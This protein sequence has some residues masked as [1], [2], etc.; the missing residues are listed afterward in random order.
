MLLNKKR[1]DISK[2][3]ERK[4]GTILSYVGMA[5][6]TAISLLYTPYMIRTVGQ[7]EYGLYNTLSSI[8]GIIAILELGFT[9][10]YIQYYSKYVHNNEYGKL[11]S[12]NTLFSTIFAIIALITLT[13]GLLCSF[14]LKLIYHDG[15]TNS[16]Y[17]EAKIMLILMSISMSIGYATTIFPCYI[18][19][20]QRFIFSKVLGLINSVLIVLSNV[21]CL[22]LGYG[23]M[24][25][26]VVSFV[27]S[28][29]NRVI[30]IY[31][32]TEKLGLRF[33]F[34]YKNI[35]KGLFKE[36]FNFSGLI[37]INIFV[38]KVNEG[39]DSIILGRFC[40]TSIVGI[41][42]VG[43][44]MSRMNTSFSV[45]I[46]GIFTSHIH[47][48]VNSYE[49]DSKEQRKALTDF[50][51]KVGRIQFLLM[52]LICSGVII[53]GRQFIYFW[54]GEGYEDAYYVALLL[55]VPG[56]VPLIQNVGIE[57]QRA[58]NR[59]NY[60]SYIYGV[61]ALINLVTSVILCQFFGAVGSALGTC[62][63]VVVANGIIMNIIYHKKI[64][65]DMI[66]FWKN[67]LRL[68]VGM[69]IPFICGILIMKFYEINSI[70]KLIAGIIVYS[71]IYFVFVW[72]F[73]MNNYEKNI[74][75]DAISKIFKKAKV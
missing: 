64:N 32:S 73:S 60:R 61:M 58:E 75:K 51:T 30:Y 68:T 36:V 31:Y 70:I 47:E 50:F 15:F 43:S 40:G 38:D 3:T 45:S 56:I 18:G 34:N 46:S 25:I 21:I 72:L 69:I 22:V 63:A 55:I 12:F 29:I 7:S 39:L 42:A 53:F 17:R 16:E 27:S 66:Y 48:L 10:S 26:V 11:K 74:I 37:A 8:I 1:T 62:I 14:N 67:I 44:A 28:L 41:Y 35:E 71:L 6:S 59:H 23:I 5:L 49:M 24:G 4:V 33:D 52:A 20:N 19:A 65:I 57:I 54:A 13:L 2:S 9:S